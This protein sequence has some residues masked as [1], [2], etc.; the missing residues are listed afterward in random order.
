L[1]GKHHPIEDDQWL[2]GV[3]EDFWEMPIIEE[4]GSLIVPYQQ[5]GEQPG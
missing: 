4:V 1:I 5:K 2:W 3:E